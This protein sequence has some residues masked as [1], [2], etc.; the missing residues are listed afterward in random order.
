MEALDL[1]GNKIGT[2]GMAVLMGQVAVNRFL[3]LLTLSGNRLDHEAAVSVAAK[4]MQSIARPMS[5]RSQPRGN[6]PRVLQRG[7]RKVSDN[8]PVLDVPSRVRNLT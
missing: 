5:R 1:F 6:L 3:R 7:R 4:T 2:R 8:R